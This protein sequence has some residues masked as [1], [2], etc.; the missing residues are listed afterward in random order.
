MSNKEFWDL[1]KPFLSNKGRLANSDISL[2]HN[3]AVVTDEQELKEI[4][5]DHYINLVEKPIGEK[6]TSLAKDTGISHY[7][8]V[9]RLI[10]E[11]YKNHPSILPIIQKPDQVMESFTFQEV[12]SKEVA[13]LLKSLDGRKSTGEDK[14]LP[15]LVS[16]AANELA[17][18]LT[19]AI[20]STIRNSCFPNDAKKAAVC[21]L[22][23]G[24]QNRPAERN[25]RP[26]SVLNTFSKIYEEV[27]KKQLIQYLDNTLSVF[28][29]AYRQA[30]GTQHVLI[31]DS[32]NGRFEVSP[33]Q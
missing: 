10:I 19:S 33:R 26:V 17:N 15:K 5:N 3:N 2:V 28:V 18:A 8:Q 7:R 27:L 24:E 32:F 31:F 23:K 6:P 13:Q 12:N 22:D 21:P 14:I 25:F 20:N 1:V 29:V 30:C 11:K 9:V 16:L 4:F